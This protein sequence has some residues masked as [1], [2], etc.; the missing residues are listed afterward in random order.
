MPHLY[1]RTTEM[2]KRAEKIISIIK[3]YG[4]VINSTEIAD[5]YPEDIPIG[6]LKSFMSGYVR[7]YYPCIKAIPR[8]GYI[9]EESEKKPVNV[10][11]NAEGYPDPTAGKA[12][13]NAM[14]SSE[15]ANQLRGEIWIRD[16]GAYKNTQELVLVL[17]ASK[18][19][20]NYIVVRDND[21]ERTYWYSGYCIPFTS[22]NGTKKFVDY[23]QIRT[24]GQN[25]FVR[26][27]QMLDEE[28]FEKVLN[29]IAE[30]FNISQFVKPKEVEVV[31]EVP[32]VVYETKEVPAPI[33]EEEAIKFLTETGWLNKHNEIVR[34][35]ERN[36]FKIEKE[37]IENHYANTDVWKARAEAWEQAFRLMCEKGA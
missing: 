16:T 8:K 9:Y 2:D 6:S 27:D 35:G 37:K 20:V 33:T 7:P 19:V 11:K 24:S 31:K 28:I 12:L 10:F 34:E 26:Y 36:M 13:A 5:L 23:R 29:G 22:T 32:T 14:M 17:G 4:S 25:S 15:T 30:R 1:V 3:E 21:L 18:G